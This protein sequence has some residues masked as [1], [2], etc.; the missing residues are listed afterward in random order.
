MAEFIEVNGLT[1]ILA[2]DGCIKTT[3]HIEDFVAA[4]SLLTKRP[5]GTV[6]LVARKRSTVSNLGHTHYKPFFK[7]A[8]KCDTSPA[9]E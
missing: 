2:E 8:T 3:I 4:L 9:V 7:T 5:N 1:N 6:V